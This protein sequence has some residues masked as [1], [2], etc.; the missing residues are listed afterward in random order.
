MTNPN[1]E[2][3]RRGFAASIVDTARRM[4][5]DP[6]VAPRD[7]AAH[8]LELCEECDHYTAAKTCE[9]CKCFMPAKTAMANV[10]CPIDNWTEYRSGN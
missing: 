3:C 5:E 8:R 6:T 9:L 7:V 1:E 4:L 2:C 10:K